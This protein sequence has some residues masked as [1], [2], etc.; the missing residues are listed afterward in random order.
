VVFVNEGQVL[1]ASTSNIMIVRD[2]VVITPKDHILRGITRGWV[3]ELAAGLGLPVEERAMT[4]AETLS[5]DEVFLTATNKYIVPV[6]QIDNQ[7]ITDGQPG[8]ITK[9]LQAAVREFVGRY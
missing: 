8:P 3:L 1:E 9:K 2:G 5:A 7:P 4:L 6:V